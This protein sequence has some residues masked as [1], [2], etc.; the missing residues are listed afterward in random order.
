LSDFVDGISP[1]EKFCAD[2]FP[3]HTYDKVHS[4]PAR[5]DVPKAKCS[6]IVDQSTI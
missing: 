3:L 4:L 5:F 2:T 6:K 1:C